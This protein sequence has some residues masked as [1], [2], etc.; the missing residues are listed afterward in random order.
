VLGRQV[1]PGFDVEPA[2]D[3]DKVSFWHR[4]GH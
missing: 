3:L 4:P 2:S 1:A